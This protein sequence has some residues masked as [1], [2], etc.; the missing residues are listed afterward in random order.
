MNVAINPASRHDVAFAANHFRAGPDDDVNAVLGVWITGFPDRH[1]API[2]EANVGFDNAP[3]IQNQR[4]G[5]HA[6]DCTLTACTLALRHAVTDGFATAK[7]HF[8]TIASCA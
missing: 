2:F 1:N 3:V 7:F 5:H 4:V 8:F 6:I